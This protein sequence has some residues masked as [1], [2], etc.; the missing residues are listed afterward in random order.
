MTKCHSG[1]GVV[2][3][4]AGEEKESNDKMEGNYKKTKGPDIQRNKRELI[5][6]SR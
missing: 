1:E 4:T 5:M 6:P 3:D 2:K